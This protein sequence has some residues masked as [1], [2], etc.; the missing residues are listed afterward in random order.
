MQQSLEKLSLQQ[1]SMWQHRLQQRSLKELFWPAAPAQ[2]SHLRMLP[3]VQQLQL[4]T[5]F[6]DGDPS[7]LHPNNVPSHHNYH[8]NGYSGG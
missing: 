6:N 4:R 2:L 8:C 1:L 3:K 7:A 5:C